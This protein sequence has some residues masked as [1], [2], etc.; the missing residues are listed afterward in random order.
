[1]GRTRT[2]KVVV[3]AAP[4]SLIGTTQRVRISDGAPHTLFGELV[5]EATAVA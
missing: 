2:D 3:V 4:P 5:A 1:M